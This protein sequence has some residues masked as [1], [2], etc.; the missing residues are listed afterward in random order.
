MRMSIARPAFMFLVNSEVKER[1][2]E[3]T[4]PFD[5]TQDS[6]AKGEGVHIDGMLVRSNLFAV[7]RREVRRNNRKKLLMQSNLTPKQRLE[8]LSIGQGAKIGQIVC[9]VAMSGTCHRLRGWS[10]MLLDFIL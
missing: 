4:S 1:Y 8:I 7:C 3:L 6:I 10:S 5:F 2:G 9:N